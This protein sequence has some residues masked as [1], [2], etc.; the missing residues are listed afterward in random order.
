MKNLIMS[1]GLLWLAQSAAAQ[2]SANDALEEKRR[3][4]TER[5][6]NLHR[7]NRHTF[8]LQKTVG[9]LKD[10]RDHKLLSDQGLLARIE[11][12][13]G[14]LRSWLGA[15][16]GMA[17]DLNSTSEGN[18]LER[19][20][21]FE[22]N[23]KLRSDELARLIEAARVLTKDSQRLSLKLAEL[24]QAVIKD[25]PE[26]VAGLNRAI[27]A[28][29]LIETEITTSF[30]SNL[31]THLTKLQSAASGVV[32]A[33]LVEL[34]LRYPELKA[35][36]DEAL[37][38]ISFLQDFAKARLEIMQ[39]SESVIAQASQSSMFAAARSLATLEQLV[40]TTRT[41]MAKSTAKQALV[42]SAINSIDASLDGSKRHYTATKNQLS[43]AGHLARF[44]ALRRPAVSR[45]CRDAKLAA[46]RNCELARLL[47]SMDL[48]VSALRR[49]SGADLS[50][51]ESQLEASLQA[52]AR[53]TGEQP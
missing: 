47:N 27:L 51:I 4:L 44:A 31:T 37:A 38:S 26:L 1:L 19:L 33:R 25:H 28:A 53:S 2:T 3:V 48:S 40:H 49:L 23:L 42:Q 12:W 14:Q 17:A 41:S 11:T 24:D 15:W 8:E 9:L 18:V 7:Q 20:P 16:E 6:A 52:P 45:D 29:G 39:L 34:A 50:Y 13:D 22:E 46:Y 35:K 21:L 43:E 30:G 32:R 10:Y 5:E 36:I